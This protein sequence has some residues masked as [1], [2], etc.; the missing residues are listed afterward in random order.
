MSYILAVDGGGTQCRAAIAAL[1]GTILGRATAGSANMATDPQG[2]MASVVDAA[3]AAMAAGGIADTPLSSIHAY[4][5]LAGANV[6]PDHSGLI[7][8][9]PFRDTRIVED[10]VIAVRGALGP[11]DGVMAVLGTGSVYGGRRDGKML[12]AGGWGFVVGDQGSGARL[13]R[14]LMEQ[15]L[16]A[17]DGVVPES[18]LTR[19]VMREHGDDP[20][21]I[22]AFGS[23]ARPADFARYAPLVFEGAD[24][25]DAIAMAV[26]A[27]A[28]SDVNAALGAIVWDGCQHL[29]LTGGLAPNYEH[30]LAETFLRILKPVRGNALAGAVELAVETFASPQA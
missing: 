22:V 29:C 5:G 30:R 10:S 26:V 7:A 14:A 4:L 8:G 19:S 25:G 18:E 20:N 13:G 3:R 11:N 27:G 9:L 23:T 1:D 21:R 6:E 15:T 16:L 12:R 17:Y 24:R 2:A 28:I